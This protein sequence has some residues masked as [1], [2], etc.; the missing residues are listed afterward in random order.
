MS[1]L[2]LGKPL[3]TE[4]AKSAV[5]GS[6]L[7]VPK[8]VAPVG[9]AGSTTKAPPPTSFGQ[10]HTLALAA[11]QKALGYTEAPTTKPRGTGTQAA[12]LGLGFREKPR[13]KALRAGVLAAL[14]GLQLL[15]VTTSTVSQPQ[16]GLP[17]VSSQH[18]SV[19]D[20]RIQNA[21]HIQRGD[22]RALSDVQ[23]LLSAWT[24]QQASDPSF[25]VTASRAND[26]LLAGLLPATPDGNDIVAFSRS[27]LGQDTKELIATLLDG[28]A[29]ALDASAR[30]L[31]ER[32]IGRTQAVSA[33]GK[34]KI[35]GDQSGGQ[36][37]LIGIPGADVEVVNLSDAAGQRS[38][39][40]DG[41]V[42]GQ[43]GA[44]GTFAGPV[45]LQA[46]D[47]LRVRMKLPEGT[48]TEWVRFSAEGLGADTRNAQV[49]LFRIGLTD[50][51]NDQI[52]LSNVNNRRM[53]SEPGAMLRF[54]NERTQ[55]IVD[56][57]VNA[58]GTFD[59][60]IFLPG[61]AGDS[62][63]VR[64]SDRKNNTDFSAVAGVI[65]V[66]G[67]GLSVQLPDPALHAGDIDAAGKPKFNVERFWG[68]LVDAG[69][70]QATDVTQGQIANCYLAA[71]VSSVAHHRPGFLNDSIR[72]ALEDGGKFT[73]REWQTANLDSEF[74]KNA[75]VE[76]RFFERVVRNGVPTYSEVWQPVDT[77]LYVRSWGGPAYGADDGPRGTAEMELWWS[78]LEKA[79]ADWKGDYNTVGNGGQ[80]TMAF[81][82]LVGEDTT[83]ID[84][85]ATNKSAA[86]DR[87]VKSVDRGRPIGA[88]TQGPSEGISYA[89]TGL[90]A[91]H[92]YSVF[93]Y[94]EKDGVKY[95]QLRNPW[96]QGEPM[97]GDG[98]ND[99]IFSLNLDDFVR[100]FAQLYSTK[101]R[102]P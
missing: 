29:F 6:D 10:A 14:A 17:S 92:G 50:K 26:L 43:V 24:A 25:V 62:F 21:G 5:A 57:Q 18:R 34:L 71:A 99:G 31:W 83:V 49:A 33:D 39:V 2:N 73:L 80:M 100:Y 75:V 32:A 53:I 38:G 22:L 82:A 72:V 58:K 89:N 93:A 54:V 20:V 69:G 13:A 97:P 65:R 30:T 11:A 51:G 36:L 48:T 68:P 15:S 63:S 87:I 85:S 95:V 94:E 37:R 81:R 28:N 90:Y 19:L 96:G 45:A 8:P 79:Y 46:G 70:I 9:T 42:V 66:G 77:D 3:S 86:W 56:V 35:M 67:S 27:F 7:P 60:G 12:V 59:A 102:Q 1:I 47:E 44:D 16:G 23:T 4:R 76:F 98:K 40:D 55:Q 74:L 64:A 101:D 61:Q 91:A 84:I 88:G 78:L 52:E 41:T